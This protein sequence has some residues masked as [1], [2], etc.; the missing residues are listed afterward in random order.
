M[1]LQVPVYSGTPAAFKM[2]PIDRTQAVAESASGTQTVR[3]SPGNYVVNAVYSGDALYGPGSASTH[4]I[5]GPSCSTFIV[6]LT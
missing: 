5:I 1:L 4:I 6:P 2:A 3:L